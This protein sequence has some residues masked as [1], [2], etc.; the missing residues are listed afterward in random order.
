[1]TLE[2]IEKRLKLLEDG[3]SIKSL[4]REYIFLLINHEWEKCLPISFQMLL[5]L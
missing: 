1:M 4:H 2:E 3:E 5:L